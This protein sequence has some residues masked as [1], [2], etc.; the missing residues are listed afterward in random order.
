MVGKSAERS[1]PKTLTSQDRWGCDAGASVFRCTTKEFQVFKYSSVTNT[2]GR[3]VNIVR[4]V[5]HQKKHSQ[6]LG[7]KAN[8]KM[9]AK[10]EK[11]P[12]TGRY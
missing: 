6:S 5:L 4:A 3:G 2:N 10:A 1:E 11:S 8:V 9:R 7:Y 12:K